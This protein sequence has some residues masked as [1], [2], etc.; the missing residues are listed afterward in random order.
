[1][2]TS[3]IRFIHESGNW[4]FID[5]KKL[6]KKNIYFNKSSFSK[7]QVFKKNDTVSFEIHTYKNKP[8]AKYMQKIVRNRSNSSTENKDY[9]LKKGEEL[10]IE[11]VEQI[12]PSF[13][14]NSLVIHP[15]KANNEWYVDLF[16]TDDKSIADLKCQRTPFFTCNKI[17]SMLDP[18]FTVT[19][20]KNDYERY[21]RDY[22]TNIDQNTFK[23]YWWIKWEQLEYNGIILEELD[24]VWEIQF[25]DIIK[26][27]QTNKVPLHK[28]QNRE[29]DQINSKDSFLFDLRAFN[30]IVRW[31]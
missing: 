27:V 18:Q 23:I 8:I 2:H 5:G 6:K 25:N 24:G 20:N 4:G 7:K 31:K 14:K 17:S 29:N 26:M 22:K 12:A 3:Y 21:L 10:E 9:W 1:M 15:E 30:Q 11:F 13:N 16:D 19:F 28:Y